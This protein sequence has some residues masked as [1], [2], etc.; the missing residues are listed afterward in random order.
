MVGLGIIC[1]FLNIT[2]TLVKLTINPYRNNDKSARASKNSGR[3]FEGK[4]FET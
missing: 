1:L 4:C 2:L 3:A